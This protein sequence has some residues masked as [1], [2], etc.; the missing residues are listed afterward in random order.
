[1]TPP[2]NG[3]VTKRSNRSRRSRKSTGTKY[4]KL[5]TKEVEETEMMDLNNLNVGLEAVKAIGK[6]TEVRPHEIYENTQYIPNKE[7]RLL[8]I[9][10]N[11]S[12]PFQKLLFY[13]STYAAIYVSLMLL[14]QIHRLQTRDVEIDTYINMVCV[15]IWV[16]LEYYRI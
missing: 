15:C 4:S 7:L 2:P 1:M 16:P 5:N 11:S 12:L 14:G 3:S 10:L 13:H 9:P 8:D 6:E